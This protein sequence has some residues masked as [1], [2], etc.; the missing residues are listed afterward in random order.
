MKPAWTKDPGGESAPEPDGPAL[1]SNESGAESRS[2]RWRTIVAAAAV[3]MVAIVVGAVLVGRPRTDG[4]LQVSDAVVGANDATV[5]AA[6]LVIDNPG[7]ADRLVSVTSPDAAEVTLHATVTD[8]GLSRMEDVESMDVPADDEL[9]LDPGGNHLMIEGTDSP[10]TD[11][12]TIRLHLE[13]ERAGDR[14]VVARAVPL[15]E[16]PERLPR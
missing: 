16:L 13:F 14:D 4:D 9:R 7:P 8:G 15:A 10:V 1:A 6:Y 3:V 12:S 5:V 11:G 2:G